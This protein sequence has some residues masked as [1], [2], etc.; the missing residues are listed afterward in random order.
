[1]MYLSQK[2]INYM[3]Y[4]IYI[5]KEYILVRNALFFFCPIY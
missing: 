5:A 4:I 1:M 2:T 3:I